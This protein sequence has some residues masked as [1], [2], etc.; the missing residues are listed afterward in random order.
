MEP[1]PL[2]NRKAPENKYEYHEKSIKLKLTY[3]TWTQAVQDLD[4]VFPPL[5]PQFISNQEIIPTTVSRYWQT[6]AELSFFRH[7]TAA[8]R[9][10]SL[11]T[12][13]CNF[14]PSRFASF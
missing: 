10:G 14:K 11:V 1:C 8:K 4:F 7:D 13:V 3:K 9:G 6:P 2:L 5:E 12:Q